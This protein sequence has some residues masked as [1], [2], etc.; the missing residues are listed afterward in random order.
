MWLTRCVHDLSAFASK[1][2]WLL[3]AYSFALCTRAEVVGLERAFVT[4]VVTLSDTCC[5]VNLIFRL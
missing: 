2:D 3:L 1:R 4:V 5:Y